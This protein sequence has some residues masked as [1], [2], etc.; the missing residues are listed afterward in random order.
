[1]SGAAAPA[2]VDLG[3]TIGSD[4]KAKEPRIATSDGVM[5]AYLRSYFVEQS[6]YERFVPGKKDALHGAVHSPG[7]ADR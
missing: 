7:A 4:G 5:L 3:F 1:M 2:V 6:R